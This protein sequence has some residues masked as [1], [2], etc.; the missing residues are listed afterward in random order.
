MCFCLPQESRT[1]TPFHQLNMQSDNHLL[2]A[3]LIRGKL[4]VPSDLEAD[5]PLDKDLSGNNPAQVP[6]A[7]QHPA[8]ESQVAIFQNDPVSNS[9]YLLL[10]IDQWSRLIDLGFFVKNFY[11]RK[12]RSNVTT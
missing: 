5:L 12:Q 9:K 3:V 6:A 10:S 7:V 1:R 4:S 8:S 2:A 11:T